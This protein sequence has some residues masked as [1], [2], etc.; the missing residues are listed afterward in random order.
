MKTT[1]EDEKQTQ[2]NLYKGSFISNTMKAYLDNE[3]HNNPFTTNHKK[4]LE[5]PMP[6]PLM[7]K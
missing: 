4:A 2:I 3:A 7:V 1:S 6:E 5:P